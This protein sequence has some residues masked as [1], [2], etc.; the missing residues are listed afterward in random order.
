VLSTRSAA[1]IQSLAAVAILGDE[2]RRKTGPR[3]LAA[4]YGERIQAEHVL[5]C[6]VRE[7]T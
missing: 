7:L 3:G 2:R 4:T 5:R 1:E 6:V